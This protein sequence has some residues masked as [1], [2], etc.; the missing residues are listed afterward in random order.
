MQTLE[1]NQITKCYFLVSGIGRLS[2]SAKIYQL[3]WIFGVPLL[4]FLVRFD[5]L[6]NGIQ[7]HFVGRSGQRFILIFSWCGIHEEA[8]ITVQ[9]MRWKETVDISMEERENVYYSTIDLII[10]S[11]TLELVLWQLTWFISSAKNQLHLELFLGEHSVCFSD[12]A[13][14]GLNVRAWEKEMFFWSA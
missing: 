11:C 12:F 3:S 13:S 2:V 14:S 5:W 7:H 10:G 1:F 9:K 6:I 4:S 8:G